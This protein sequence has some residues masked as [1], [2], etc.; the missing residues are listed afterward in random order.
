ML[1]KTIL[2][3][4]VSKSTHLITSIP[5]SPSEMKKLRVSLSMLQSDLSQ[6]NGEID[7]VQSVLDALVV[8]RKALG[9]CIDEHRAAL[10]P[11]RRL[12]SEIL[13]DIFIKSLPDDWKVDI[14][15]YR[16]AVLLPGQI[17]IQWRSTALS[18]GRLWSAVNINLFKRSNFP[19]DVALAQTW[20]KR[21][22][23]HPVSIKFVAIKVPN[24]DATQIFSIIVAHCQRWRRAAFVLPSSMLN[25]L[26]PAT[27]CLP[28]LEA[29]SIS[30]AHADAG[31][32]DGTDT[33]KFAPKL[34][35][36]EIGRN[37][38]VNSLQ[39]PWAQLT[40]IHLRNSTPMES[41][42][43]LRQCP[44]LVVCKSWLRS[45]GVD[46]EVSPFLHPHLSKLSVEMTGSQSFDHFFDCFVL[47]AL[48][49]FDY[50]QE[51]GGPWKQRQFNSLLSRSLCFLRKLSISC[52]SQSNA[53]EVLECLRLAPSLIELELNL[54]TTVKDQAPC[55]IN[56][57][58]ARLNCRSSKKRGLPCLLP[59]LR[60]FTLRPKF[61][62]AHL[63]AI[64]DMIETRWRPASFAALHSNS[65]ECE[66]L[67]TVNVGF[68][69][70]HS[71]YPVELVCRRLR[72]LRD[73][74]RLVNTSPIYYMSQVYVYKGTGDKRYQ[75]STRD[76]FP[77]IEW[78]LKKFLVFKNMISPESSAA[79]I[80]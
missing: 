65:E 25:V 79:R 44:Q 41:V 46:A 68:T 9:E 60:K 6:L 18:T 50:H 76:F 12:P 42:Q 71:K 38:E 57:I 72:R 70:A 77:R 32:E 63:N 48:C 21:S 23:A 8:R 69:P 31:G 49:D 74:G 27:R 54:T 10:A 30:S 62:H 80:E 78:T 59:K 5:P 14:P 43:I 37:I 33:W 4:P 66:Q 58:L 36:L 26:L 20:L 52:S 67:S 29:L 47:P 24:Y 15:S 2:S 3:S 40:T 45:A 39:V 13:S 53:E 64:A 35:S 7:Q 19:R 75:T 16:R 1:D 34:R 55:W 11:I 61:P 51:S 56:E 73:D 28:N 22:G 17:C